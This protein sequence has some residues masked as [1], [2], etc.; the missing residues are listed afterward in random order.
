MTKYDVLLWSKNGSANL[1]R[2]LKRFD[3]VVP[4]KII[5]QKILIDDCSKDN[6]RE[7]ARAHNW[8][9]VTNRGHGISEGANTGLEFVETKTFISIEQ[10]ILLSREW[11]RKI[12]PLLKR[13]N[14]AIASGVRLP[15]SPAYLRRIQEFTLERY[16]KHGRTLARTLDNT[17]YKTSIIKDLGGFPKLPPSRAGVD[18]EL[19]RSLSERR[20]MRWRVDFSVI[21][22]HLRAG[23]RDELNHYYW[24]GKDNNPKKSLRI[25]A[26][27]PL[28]GLTIAL[29]K[30]SPESF[31]VYP[32]M[33]FQ[34]LRGALEK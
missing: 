3:E 34:F 8:R 13:K 11:F 19:Y 18:R 24:Y 29:K 7:I 20:D 30:R 16:R 32:L 27:S 2:V 15:N 12:P 10:D 23:L 14:V 5:N 26:T 28:M 6:T 31:F 4:E 22:T 9:V 21:S 1:P 17:I 25:L 33:R